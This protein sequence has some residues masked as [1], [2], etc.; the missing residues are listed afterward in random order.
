[1]NSLSVETDVSESALGISVL[2]SSELGPSGAR[3]ARSWTDLIGR[4]S[5]SVEAGVATSST[6]S[7]SCSLLT[8][9]A[10]NFEEVERSVGGKSTGGEGLTG[11]KCNAAS[12]RIGTRISLG[13]IM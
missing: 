11:R 6:S 9:S 7:G 12:L 5:M 3:R 10:A 1:M 13:I 2:S 4:A 8:M